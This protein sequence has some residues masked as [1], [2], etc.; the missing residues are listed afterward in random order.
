MELKQENLVCL[1]V[2]APIPGKVKTRLQPDFTAEESLMLHKAMAEDLVS[3]LQDATNY[4]L[5][6]FFWP[7][8]QVQELR[9]WLG[10][11]LDYV[12]QRGDDLGSRMHHAFEWAFQRG[13]RKTIVIGSDIPTLE[14]VILERA[15]T[16]LNDSDVVLGPSMDGGYYLIGLRATRKSLFQ[17]IPWGTGIVF[18][19]TES[20]IEAENLRLSRLPV[21]RDI[22]T[23]DDV[24]Y[25]WRQ[26]RDQPE[27]AEFS[28]IGHTRS[29]LYDIIRNK[30]WEM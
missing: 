17:N 1:F 29:V 14:S 4:H 11:G 10:D 16:L 22:D 8:D 20:V 24:R 6:L 21:K 30:S 7:P 15:F 13:F 23:G 12:P 19:E 3:L 18:K 28:N 5:V 2:K 27:V 26:Y 25:L 9:D